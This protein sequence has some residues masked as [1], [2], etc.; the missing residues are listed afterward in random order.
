MN[1]VQWAFFHAFLPPTHSYYLFVIPPIILLFQ[2]PL[3]RIHLLCAVFSTNNLE[4]KGND[5]DENRLSR[6]RFLSPLISSCRKPSVFP[7]GTLPRESE[8]ILVDVVRA[9]SLQDFG[10]HETPKWCG[11]R[12]YLRAIAVPEVLGPFI[13]SHQILRKENHPTGSV[14]HTR[15]VARTYPRFSTCPCNFHDERYNPRYNFSSYQDV[16]ESYRSLFYKFW[17]R[18]RL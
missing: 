5:D 1:A 18:A 16:R 14:N 2:F 12:G 9:K 4:I 11:P 8:P 6:Y 13:K 7:S 3:F 15:G 17:S 10:V